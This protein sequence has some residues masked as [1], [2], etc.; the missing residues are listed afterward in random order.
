MTT[1]QEA[2]SIIDQRWDQLA[3]NYYA[4]P[5]AYVEIVEAN[6]AALG[7]PVLLQSGKTI[8]IPSAPNETE[9]TVNLP[10]WRR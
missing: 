6:I 9:M 5:Y 1:F 7:Y 8:S 4:D 10:P 2:T 3:D